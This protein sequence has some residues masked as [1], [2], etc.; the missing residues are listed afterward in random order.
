MKDGLLFF[1]IVAGVAGF[2]VFLLFPSPF[3]KVN[4]RFFKKTDNRPKFF[5][6]WTTFFLPVFWAFKRFRVRANHVT[7]VSVLG[8]GASVWL[9][10]LDP[11]LF[12]YGIAFFSSLDFLDGELA[13]LDGNKERQLGKFW[14]STMDRVAEIIVFVQLIIL[15]RHDTLWVFLFSGLLG[16]GLFISYVRAVGEILHV[17][18]VSCLMERAYRMAHLALMGLVLKVEN[19]ESDW[20]LT[21]IWLGVGL[22]LCLVS[23]TR[24][25]YGTYV[26]LR[27][28]K[29]PR[30]PHALLKP[31]IKRF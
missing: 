5:A 23:A 19:Y 26:F 11:L 16:V 17:P 8:L 24:R 1:P 25:F 21:S 6:F 29:N 20:A 18:P 28:K 31:T 2:F 30:Q 4:R 10:L 9:V 27:N 13:L 12:G 3:L 7:T 15:F 22:L 14:D